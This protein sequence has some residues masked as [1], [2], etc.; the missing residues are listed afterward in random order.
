[1]S[2]RRPEASCRA[3]GR[4]SGRHRSLSSKVGAGTRFVIYLPVHRE[5]AGTGK[6]RQTAK[7][8]A[9]ELWGTYTGASV[10]HWEGDTLVFMTISTKGSKDNGVILDRT[11]L[12]LSED[13]RIVTRMR[14]V[15]DMTLEAQITI[16]ANAASHARRDIP[17]SNTVARMTNR[18]TWTSRL[19]R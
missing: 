11:G 15:N 7:E 17:R 16:E 1:M 19:K 13:A 9:D 10:G 8:T 2:S 4:R 5:E 6:P 14:K 18:N 12:I 3:I